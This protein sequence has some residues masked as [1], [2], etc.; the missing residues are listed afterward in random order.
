MQHMQY[1]GEYVQVRVC[2][3]SR[4]AEEHVGGSSTCTRGPRAREEVGSGAPSAALPSAALPSAALPSGALPSAAL[5]SAALPS[6]ALPSAALPS[7]ALPSAALPSAPFPPGPC[8]PGPC[9]PRP[10]PPRPSLRALPS[11]ALPSAALPSAA[12]PSAALPSAALPSGA[13]P[14]AAL[15]S[16]ALPSAALPSA[17]LPSGALPSGSLPSAALPSGALPSAALPSGSLPSAPFPQ[18]KLPLKAD[19][20]DVGRGHGQDTRLLQVPRGVFA[21]PGSREGARAA[22]VMPWNMFVDKT[23][24][25]TWESRE[26]GWRRAGEGGKVTLQGLDASPGCRR[27]ESVSAEQTAEGASPARQERLPL[28][29]PSH[30]SDTG[31]LRKLTA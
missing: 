22:G 1:G 27:E 9:P 21:R 26:E 8:P 17:A 3:C 15:P 4:P 25:A 16:A 24:T 6:G 18:G 10:C 29:R 12:L 11:A 14:S 28:A 2:I 13:L 20:R 5:P 30:G 7:A 31:S 23:S 19:S